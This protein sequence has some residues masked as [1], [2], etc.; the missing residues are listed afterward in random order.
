MSNQN[1]AQGSPLETMAAKI[2]GDK[3]LPVY[4]FLNIMERY[5]E[6]L[7]HADEVRD[8]L[9]ENELCNRDFAHK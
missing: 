4:D 6:I 1:Q 7:R 3:Y 5:V 9:Y 2:C 8:Q